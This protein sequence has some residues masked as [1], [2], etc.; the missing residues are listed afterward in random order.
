[1]ED[2]IAFDYIDLTGDFYD[3]NNNK[4]I[5]AGTISITSSFG[6]SGKSTSMQFTASAEAVPEPT[7]MVGL[8]IAGG[9]GAFGLKKKKQ[10]QDV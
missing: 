1:M 6:P 4:Y 8:A 7:T 2:F 3:I 5:G 9:L 10:S